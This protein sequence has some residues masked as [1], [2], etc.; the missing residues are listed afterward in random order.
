MNI[1]FRGKYGTKSKIWEKRDKRKYGC[2]SQDYW[3]GE[4]CSGRLAAVLKTF[5]SGCDQYVQ[6]VVPSCLLQEAWLPFFTPSG[7][8][9]CGNN[10]VW[11]TSEPW[12]KIFRRKE[13]LFLCI[14]ASPS[15]DQ[16]N[17]R[18]ASAEENSRAVLRIRFGV[19][20]YCQ[21]SM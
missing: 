3:E 4:N 15:I 14:N 2:F 11:S 6:A 7:F 12:P 16:T 21:V 19:G 13:I 8:H 1:L 5:R 17:L 10:S 20:N 9:V 18:R